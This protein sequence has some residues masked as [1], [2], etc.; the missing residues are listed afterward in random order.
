MDT[1]YISQLEIS[2]HALCE[3]YN[4]PVKLDRKIAKLS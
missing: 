3:E 1:M 4:V 2:I